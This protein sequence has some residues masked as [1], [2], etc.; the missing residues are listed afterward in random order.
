MGSFA[1]NIIT[2]TAPDQMVPHTES[3]CKMFQGAIVASNASGNVMNPLIYNLLCC[4]AN[5]APFLQEDGNAK[6]AYQSLI[7]FFINTLQVFAIND[8]DKVSDDGTLIGPFD[9]ADPLIT[10]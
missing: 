1:L 8:S 2:D 9:D 4:L 7:P 6:N 3:I 10:N 5:L